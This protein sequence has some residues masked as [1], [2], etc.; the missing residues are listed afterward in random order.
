MR[1]NDIFDAKLKKIGF[2]VY[3]AYVDGKMKRIIKP[4]PKLENLDKS[5]LAEL[6]EEAEIWASEIFLVQNWLDSIVF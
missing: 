3:W 4:G 5:K 1:Y 2:V 6:Q